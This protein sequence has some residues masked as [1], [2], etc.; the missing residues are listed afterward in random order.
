MMLRGAKT[1]TTGPGRWMS[2][3][4]RASPSDAAIELCFSSGLASDA[5]TVWVFVARIE[6]VNH[7]LWP[8][9][10]L[11]SPSGLARAHLG[12]PGV[13]SGFSSWMLLLGM[14]P[15]DRHRFHFEEVGASSFKE[16]SDSWMHRA[17]HHDRSVFVDDRDA[18]ACVVE[19]RLKV[20][21]RIGWLSPV[22][23]PILRGVFHHRHLRLRSRFG[24]TSS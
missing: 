13:M 4:Q 7:E 23:R 16:R 1:V 8:V 18:T 17:W 20:S 12:D 15:I 14:V 5:E 24:T 3:L 9:V 2:R 6:G 19:D 21:P 22:I 10:R 11:T